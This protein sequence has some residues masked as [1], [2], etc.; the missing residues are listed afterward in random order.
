MKI[1]SIGGYNEVGKNMTAIEVNG[2]VVICDMGFFMEKIIPLQEETNVVSDELLIKEGAVPDDSVLHDKKV[3]AIVASHA[4][5]DHIGAIPVLAERYNCPVIGTPYTIEIIKHLA[6]DKRK[7]KLL[8]QLLPVN[9]GSSV[10]V[11]QNIKIELVHITHSIPQA[12]LI[13]VHTTEGLVTYLNDYKLDNTP[14]MGKKPDYARMEQLAKKGIKVHI[15]E[16]V[17]IEECER[18]ASEYIAQIMLHDALNRAYLSGKAVVITT[19]ASHIARIRNII[20]ANQNRRKIVCI[21]RSMSTYL[22]AADKLKLIDLDGVV[23]CR[24]KNQSGEIMQKVAQKPEDYLLIVTGN[25]GEPNSVLSSLAKDELGY[26]L[27]KGD[28]AIFSSFT[29]PSPINKANKHN[30]EILLR[31][32]GTRVI[33]NVHVSG[34]AKREDHRDMIRLLK[35]EIIIPS[36]GNT[37]KLANFASLAGEEGYVLG[38]TVHIM[39]NGGVLDI[40]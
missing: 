36:H 8:G 25:Q 26:N 15:E 10:K 18:T 22:K 12:T 1:Y 23:L 14:T 16:S 38:K 39:S 28:E 27:Q 32:K 17:R 33:N 34:H 35:P 30:L 19:F 2:E 29:I 4:H 40:K 9:T 13:A 6:K 20:K 3:V 7:K 11:T 37:E 21:G 5:L 31:K 24:S